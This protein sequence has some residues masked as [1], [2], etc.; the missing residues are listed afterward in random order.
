MKK[1]LLAKIVASL[2]LFWI[3]I[4]IVWTAL[5]FI[6]SPKTPVEDN[7]LSKKIELSKEQIEALNKISS[8]SGVNLVWTWAEESE[9]INE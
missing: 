7:Y 4:G 2:A 6:F 5:L 8:S 1:W 9:S 3:I